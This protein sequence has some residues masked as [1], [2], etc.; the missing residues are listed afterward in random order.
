M[1]DRRRLMLYAAGGLAAVFAVLNWGI[2]PFLDRSARLD[3]GIR[4]ARRQLTSATELQAR[5]ASLSGVKPKAQTPASFSLYGRFEALAAQHGLT[6]RMASIQ[7]S[8]KILPGNKRESLLNVK[9][10][11]IDLAGFLALLKD[12]EDDPAGVRVRQCTLAVAGEG[13]L[14]ADMTLSVVQSE[15]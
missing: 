8:T 6:Q 12:V 15:E 14:Q 13:L 9:F 10:T 1:I 11:G 2:F 7:P 3:Q 5:Q 4:E